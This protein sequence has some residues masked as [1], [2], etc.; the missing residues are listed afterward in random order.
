MADGFLPLLNEKDYIGLFRA[1]EASNVLPKAFQKNGQIRFE[2]IP[3]YDTI[4]EERKKEELIRQLPN[5]DYLTFASSS[6]VKA[7]AKMTKEYHGQMPEIISIGPVT[8]KTLEECG[9]PVLK[10]AKQYTVKGI[11]EA[12]LENCKLL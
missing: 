10:T 7:F 1:K 11:C 4:I 8:T 5:I 9:Y 3:L 6:A 12:I 2:E